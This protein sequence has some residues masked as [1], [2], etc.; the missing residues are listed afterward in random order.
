[1]NSEAKK[2]EDGKTVDEKLTDTDSPAHKSE[3]N[4]P[5]SKY[6]C[7]LS[8]K[9]VGQYSYH[10]KDV[11]GCGF[12][13]LVYKGIKNGNKD[14]VVALKVIKLKNLTKHLKFLLDN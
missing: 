4:E 12:S 1:M 9:K 11:I 14:S 6:R 2:S 10:L 7:H 13:S 5:I 8:K 3:S